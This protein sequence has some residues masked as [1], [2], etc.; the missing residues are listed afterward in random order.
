V[1]AVL[2]T[3]LTARGGRWAA[4]AVAGAI[5]F[6]CLGVVAL[7][8]VSVAVPSAS[9]C[10]VPDARIWCAG[11]DRNG[12]VLAAAVVFGLLAVIAVS[13]VV[14]ALVE[15]AL[16]LIAGDG[17]PRRA[18]GG[19][20]TQ[21]RTSRQLRRR[22]RLESL[23]GSESS[24]ASQLAWYPP[25]DNAM[26]PTR[27]GNAFAALGRRIVH[28]HGLGLSTCW[29]LLEQAL[30]DST[31]AR[32]E[33]ASTRLARRIQNLLW[34][35]LALVWLP[36][37]PAWLA[38][39]VACT[40]VVLALLLWRGIAAAVEQ[41]CVLV[42]AAVLARRRSMYESVGWEPPRSTIEEPA[43]GR[44]LTAYL[45]RLDRFDEQ[46]LIWPVAADG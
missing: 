8:D 10:A 39:V 37:L 41:Y 27:A 26:R 25:N 2:D 30:D 34:A 12:L 11:M 40:C 32:V 9:G 44:A 45:N 35:V 13:S 14:A 15:P 28:R 36:A 42:E 16:T 3:L 24:A 43:R 46:P 38:L 1:D 4:Q 33:N 7:R 6:W 5:A 21:W 20:F 19:E 23:L 17:W 31:R 18:G 29:P 22:R